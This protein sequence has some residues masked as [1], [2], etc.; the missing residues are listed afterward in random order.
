MN[1]L[2]AFFERPQS[3]AAKI[4][5]FI[6]IFAIFFSVGSAFLE[7]Q[8]PQLVKNFSSFFVISEKIILVLF[9]IEYF[10]RF[11][12]AP[13]KLKFFWGPFNLIDLAAILPFFFGINASA[14]RVFRLLRLLKIARHLHILEVFHFRGTILQKIF[15][16]LVV[17]SALKLFVWFLESRGLWI[18]EKSLGEL[19]AI[20]G[21][22]LG[23]ILA[24]KISTTSGKYF[25]IR[26]SFFRIFG[27]MEALAAFFPNEKRLFAHWLRKL[28]GV[29]RDE[30]RSVLDFSAENK[31]LF[32]M[33][34]KYETPPAEMAILVKDAATEANFL[35]Q[36]RFD[37]VP[38]AYNL[39][40]QQVTLLY[41]FLIVIFLPGATGLVSVI[42]ATYI[43]YGL[44]HVTLDFDTVTGSEYNLI[45]VSTNDIEKFILF[46]EK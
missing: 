29:F 11:I 20:I 6:L 36:K 8:F 42:V 46:L 27:L 13:K 35:L 30:K 32:D 17:L 31:R 5:Q 25:S 18:S 7:V 43:L 14:A 24:E 23:I 1:K 26:E 33:I 38:T 3:R 22:A 34:Q 45:S 10:L 41:L 40:L 28:L 12:S 2:H 21:F 44:Y 37:F 16:L 39:L 9:S 4:V 15:P 19:F